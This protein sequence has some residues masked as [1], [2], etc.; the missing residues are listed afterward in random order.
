MGK[1][2]YILSGQWQSLGTSRRNL[3]DMAGLGNSSFPFIHRC[4]ALAAKFL[5]EKNGDSQ[6]TI[7][8]MGHCHI[9]S[10][11]SYCSL[12]NAVALC[13]PF[14]NWKSLLGYNTHVEC[15]QSHV[16]HLPCL[17]AWLW[18]YSES[19]R[20]CARS[21]SSVVALMEDYPHFTF[22]CSQVRF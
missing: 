21:W 15:V 6:H 22:T 8:A 7:H 11:A 2:T 19:I 10:G 18:P 3:L 12:R 14:S 13:W 9:D 16:Y 1:H 17:A 5:S 20:K 4:R